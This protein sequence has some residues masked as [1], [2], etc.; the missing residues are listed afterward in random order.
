MEEE[1]HTPDEKQSARDLH[2]GRDDRGAH[3]AKQAVEDLQDGQSLGRCQERPEDIVEDG[4]NVL[5]GVGSEEVEAAEGA[6]CP[7]S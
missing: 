2:C 3:D 1:H 5:R 4:G 6:G 7:E